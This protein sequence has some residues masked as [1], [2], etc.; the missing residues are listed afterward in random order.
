GG[1]LA[2]QAPLIQIGGSTS[3]ADTLLLSPDFFSQ[4]GFTAFTLTGLGA[5]TGQQDQFLPGVLIAPGT[6]ITPVAQSL[7][8]NLDLNGPGTVTLTPTTLP[9]GLRPPVSLSF[10]APGVRSPFAAGNLPVVRGDFVM[11]EG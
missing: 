3:N 7:L 1:S 8:A 5:A 2:I 4:G 10:R 6:A 9:Q 11:G